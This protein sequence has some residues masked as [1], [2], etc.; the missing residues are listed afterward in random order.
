MRRVRSWP[1]PCG[2]TGDTGR[3]GPGVRRDSGRSVCHDASGARS[4]SR[5]D[6]ADLGEGPGGA[7]GL[8]LLLGVGRAAQHRRPGIHQLG[9]I[10]KYLFLYSLDLSTWVPRGVDER[11]G[12]F[13]RAVVAK[14]APPL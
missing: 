1:A 9:H 8:S 2:S 14:L 4:R 6:E 3:G 5:E 7:A 11:A 13:A 12:A 10:R